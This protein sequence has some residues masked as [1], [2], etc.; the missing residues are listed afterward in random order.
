MLPLTE[1]VLSQMNQHTNSCNNQIVI[2][3]K[4]GL[5]T[6]VVILFLVQQDLV[7]VPHQ[8][9][10]GVLVLEFSQEW[11]GCHVECDDGLRKMSLIFH[12]PFIL[13][14]TLKYK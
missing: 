10:R 11:Y 1:L 12:K 9:E 14:H 2:H 6:A 4:H 7:Q 5:S 13:Q 3:N 8:V